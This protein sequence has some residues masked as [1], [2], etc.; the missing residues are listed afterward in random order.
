[1]DVWRTRMSPVRKVPSDLVAIFRIAGARVLIMYLV[2]IARHLPDILRSRTLRGADEG[3]RGQVYTFRALGTQVRLEGSEFGFAREIYGRAVYFRPPEVILE[4]GDTVVDLGANVGVFTALASVVASRVIAV[5]AQSGF[6]DQI[7]EN[8]A[9][10][11]AR[12]RVEVEF[13]LIGAGAG[14]FSDTTVLHS[15]SHF[16]AEPPTL[17]MP[18]LMR[19][20]ALDHID[21]LKGDIEG[22]E[23]ALFEGG[24]EWLTSV[25]TMAMEVHPKFGD[26]DHLVEIL[27]EAGF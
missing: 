1:M 22:S 11:G 7:Y 17:T 20:H 3:M 5:E 25:D 14:A 27:R 12:N 18:D 15:A 10:N 23:F 8:A 24:S 13:G 4:P 2:Q 19:R 21:F 6:V 9:R 26:V 16:G